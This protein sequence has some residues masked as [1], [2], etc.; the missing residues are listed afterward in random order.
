MTPKNSPGA[1]AALSRAAAHVG[2]AIAEVHQA[3]NEVQLVRHAPSSIYEDLD[4]ALKMLQN[5]H[6]HLSGL[7]TTSTA[8]GFS[9]R[10]ETPEEGP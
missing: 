1:K 5:Q 2:K 10:S 4:D 6:A 9:L 8:F 3:R 7:S